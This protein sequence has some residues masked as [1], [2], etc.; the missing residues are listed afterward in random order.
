VRYNAFNFSIPHIYGLLDQMMKR[1][2]KKWVAVKMPELKDKEIDTI[3]GLYLNS[4]HCK[5]Y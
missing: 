3:I 4:Q 2:T 5:D 1:M